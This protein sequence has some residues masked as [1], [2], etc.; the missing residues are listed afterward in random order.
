M[1]NMDQAVLAIREIAQNGNEEQAFRDTQSL[2]FQLVRDN[3]IFIMPSH[4]LKPDI[5]AKRAFRPYTAPL[6]GESEH[7]YIRIFSDRKL[8]ARFASEHD[9]D[10]TCVAEIS[11]I[12]LIQ[13]AKYWFVRGS[14]GFLLNDGGEWITISL[15][16]F[17]QVIYE[18]LIDQPQK[19]NQEFVDLIG[20][21]YRC[22]SVYS[23]VF[24]LT[25]EA[26]PDKQTVPVDGIETFC[27][28]DEQLA[29]SYPPE[30]GYVTLEVGEEFLKSMILKDGPAHITTVYGMIKTTM[31]HIRYAYAA[32]YFPEEVGS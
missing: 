26:E 27:F 17:L 13:L 14:Y 2:F 31:E 15:P 7:L 3:V 25:S 8:S 21:I 30:S 1:A 12:E 16:D 20:F 28:I 23:K 19:Y 11:G 32:A 18:K 5:F 22:K 4:T 24:L 10:P 29:G 9:I 6:E